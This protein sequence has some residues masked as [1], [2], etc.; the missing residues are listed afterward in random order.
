ME[1]T[2]FPTARFS[3][4]VSLRWLPEPAFENTDTVV[5]SVRKWYV[6]LRVDKGTGTIDW[7]IAGERIVES[8]EPGEF[9]IMLRL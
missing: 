6:D 5:L 9:Y 1:R 4:R 7:A 2:D 3:T 8:D